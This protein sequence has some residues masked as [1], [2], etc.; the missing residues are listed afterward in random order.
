MDLHI[1]SGFEEGEIILRDLGKIIDEYWA[2]DVLESFDQFSAWGTKM[3][4][5]AA[6]P[7]QTFG[8]LRR[9][10]NADGR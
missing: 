9:R 1:I 4:P 8:D 3:V 6:Q 5:P 2:W 10:R 7:S